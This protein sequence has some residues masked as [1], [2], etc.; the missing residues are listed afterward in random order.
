MLH[1]VR[2]DSQEIIA[3]RESDR[4]IRFLALMVEQ[5]RISD[6]ERALV[7]QEAQEV[8]R[9]AGYLGQHGITGAAMGP[10]RAAVQRQANYQERQKIIELHPELEKEMVAA[11]EFRPDYPEPKMTP[12]LEKPGAALAQYRKLLR[13]IDEKRETGLIERDTAYLAYE[14]AIRLFE[15]A[16]VFRGELTENIDNILLIKAYNV[17]KNKL[18]DIRP[19]LADELRNLESRRGR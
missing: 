3:C 4:I 11:I 7:R 1:T 5:G 12:A 13:Y 8:H 15:D 14:P 17:I 10:E 19:D 2:M 6:F 18:L 16:G 9:Q